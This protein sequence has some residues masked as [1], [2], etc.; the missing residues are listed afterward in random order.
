MNLSHYVYVLLRHPTPLRFVAGRL[1]VFTGF[2]RLL[3]ID[4]VDYRLRF[5]PSNLSLNLWI[6]PH[7]R[8]EGL[9][10]FKAYLRPGDTVLD[11]GANI[12]DTALAASTKAG[13]GGR[14]LA[15]EP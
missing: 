4:Q 11:V 13:P 6:N 15:F 5:H 10:F 12:G 14:V 9:A 7:H 1:L 2:C 3:I 8:D